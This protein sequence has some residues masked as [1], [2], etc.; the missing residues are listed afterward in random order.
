MHT[1]NGE[2]ISTYK[3][4]DRTQV[5]DIDPS[6][7]L[8][9]PDEEDEDQPC[10]A[11]GEDDNED[12]LMYC[13][14]CQKL[15]HTYCVDLQEV[16]YG[17]WFCDN[18]RAQRDVD[19]RQGVTRP[20]R[21]TRRRTRGQ[22]R[23]QR[24]SQTAHDLS[25]NQIW[26]N[27]WSRINL[28]LDFPYEEDDS[29]TYFRRHREHNQANRQ[30]HDAWLRRMQVAEL[31]GAGSRFRESE[32]AL[33][34][35]PA[36]HSI[37]RGPVRASPIAPTEDADELMAWHAF[38]QATRGPS[39]E[40]G[41][42]RKK[43]RK[44]RT[45]SPA[46][47]EEPA[48]P[49]IKRRR[50]SQSTRTTPERSSPIAART[51]PT[52][53]PRLASPIPRRQP[54]V[55]SAAPS[56]LQSLLQE[57]ED[58]ST[59]SHSNLHRPSPRPAGSPAAEQVSP[60][61]SSPAVSPLPS[62][63]SSPRATSATPPPTTLRPSSP[64]G[65]TSSIQPV[66]PSTDP[67]YRPVSPGVNGSRT[68]DRRPNAS[69]SSITPLAQPKPR[70]RIP[71]ILNPPVTNEVI[72]IKPTAAES[73]PTRTTMSL[74]AKADVQKLVATALKPHY[75]EQTIT[76]DEYTNINREIS[77]MLYDK[78]GDSGALDGDGKAQWEKVASEEVSKAINSLRAQG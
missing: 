60:R 67:P 40:P 68:T 26:Q 34:S 48:A 35:S 41:S 42:S 76:K 69:N 61:P 59:S 51:L 44:S 56:F 45:S 28:D 18:C 29:A 33:A 75:N 24:T 31:H 53:G 17:H 32:P 38:E 39:S 2:V 30:A 16:P 5:A 65:L 12:V 10:Q 74:N 23:R 22:Q 66:F 63:H 77:R 11:C 49:A 8:E 4:E 46:A 20:R 62:T 71:P 43:K 54:A 25:W 37:P 9:L 47:T 55:E 57:V 13:D 64:A 78:I 58:S 7:F 70:S 15:W 21:A 3:V 73:S 6:M 72:P 14:G 50:I 27:V 1:I 19:P 52:M 36:A